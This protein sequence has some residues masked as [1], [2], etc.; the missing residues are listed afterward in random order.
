MHYRTV[1]SFLSVLLKLPCDLSKANLLKSTYLRHKTKGKKAFM[2][3]KGQT[4]STLFDENGSHLQILGGS[5]TFS[6][7][8]CLL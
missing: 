3:K 2:K 4:S 8:M 6:M 7:Q 5:Y 1:S